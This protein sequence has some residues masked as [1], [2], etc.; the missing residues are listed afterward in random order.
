[1]ELRQRWGSLL[2]PDPSL[3]SAYNPPPGDRLSPLGI[4]P[5]LRDT[6]VVKSSIL[7]ESFPLIVEGVG[8]TPSRP[9]SLHPIGRIDTT[10]EGESL[11]TPPDVP[12]ESRVRGW[13]SPLLTEVWRPTQGEGNLGKCKEC[14]CITNLQIDRPPGRGQRTVRSPSYRVGVISGNNL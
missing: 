3:S 11:N 8:D 14:R 12:P 7:L 4:P 10:Q 9:H 1:M 13:K 2:S 6:K 5:G